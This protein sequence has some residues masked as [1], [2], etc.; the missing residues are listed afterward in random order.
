MPRIPRYERQRTIPAEATSPLMNVAAAGRVGEAAQGFADA[1]G[2][3]ADALLQ[4]KKEMQ[5]RDDDYAVSRIASWYDEEHLAFNA[6]QKQL[7]GPDA[8]G[9]QERVKEFTAQAVKKYAEGIESPYVRERVQSHIEYRQAE[10]ERDISLHE[11]VEGKRVGEQTEALKLETQ[12]NRAYHGLGAVEENVNEY[13]AFINTRLANKDI[14]PEEA[15][16][17]ISVGQDAIAQKRIYG[18]LAR[19][20]KAGLELITSG[21]F[22]KYLLSDTKER[23][24]KE[25]DIIAAVL[26][27]KS[28]TDLGLDAGETIYGSKKESAPLNEMLETARDQLGADSKAYRVAE[29]R[30]HA[31]YAE[32]RSALAEEIRQRIN[33]VYTHITKVKLDG[34]IP[35]IKD[36]PQEKWDAL[37]RVAPQEANGIIEELGRQARDMTDRSEQKEIQRRVRWSD[38]WGGLVRN[39]DALKKADLDRLLATGRIGREQYNDLKQRQA[40]LL[41]GRHD[42][43][44]GAAIAF[45]VSDLY[46]DH[47]AGIFGDP[48]SLE[49]KTALAQHIEGL[50]LWSR[51]NPAKNPVT[52]FYQ[53][54]VKEKKEDAVKRFLRG[55]MEWKGLA[56]EMEENEKKA[57]PNRQKAI[58]ILKANKKPVTEANINYVIG[59]LGKRK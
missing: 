20:K 14:S 13:I 57:D 5:R 52:D 18:L 8:Y 37:R 47:A 17:K 19:D 10:L 2:G 45:V 27:D 38:T 59:Q 43:V 15:A 6:Q 16:L 42:P 39:T 56:R 58:D 12:M 54:Y 1:A 21:I 28:A 46:G 55:V 30:I 33:D 40:D 3:F 41:N 51:N 9:S 11:A 4:R 25:A 29:M 50:E 7:K 53:V 23:L 49:S 26:E 32:D 22:D 36:V 48:D 44:R 31:L 34:R 24:A 35:T